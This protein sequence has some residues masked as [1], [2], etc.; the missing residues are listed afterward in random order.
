MDLDFKNLIATTASL[1]TIIQFLTGTLV[2]L[3]IV[4]NKSTADMSSLPF[5]SGCLST[6]LWLRYGFLIEDTS[7]ILVNTVGSTLFF[8]YVVTFYLY[9][10]R[11]G[12][13]LQQFMLCLFVLSMV[14]LYIHKTKS[15]E[16]ARSHL[17]L[18]CA[19]VTIMFFAAPLASLFH[20][21]RIKS[22]DSL[23]YHLILATF[24]VCLQWFAYGMMLNDK[25]IQV[26]N[27]IGCIFSALQLS[28]F[29]IYPN[30]KDKKEMTSVV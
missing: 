2:C 10:V 25:F 11:R 21:I 18:I 24:V 30:P 7:L 22:A 23:P 20:V 6:S 26:P 28:L 14:L 13:V 4:K 27:F 17:G 12:T 5:I 1:C 16:E 15:D 3:K 29:I 19:S 8:S 9:S